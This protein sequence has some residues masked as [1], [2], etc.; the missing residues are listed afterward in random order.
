MKTL[1]II[2]EAA[3]IKLQELTPIMRKNCPTCKGKGMI[4]TD[5]VRKFYTDCKDCMGKIPKLLTY[6]E[7][8]I[9]DEFINITLQ[10]TRNT[11]TTD[12]YKKL[13]EIIEKIDKLIMKYSMIMYRYNDAFSYG[14]GTAAAM[15]IKR[16]IDKGY[17]CF[18][19]NNS[20]FLDL[21]FNF[22]QGDEVNFKRTKIY[23]FITGVQVLWID[24]FGDTQTGNMP[25]GSYAYKKVCTFLN[26]RKIQNRF[27]ILSTDATKDSFRGTYIGALTGLIDQNYLPFEIQCNTGKGK[28][29]AIAKL[30]KEDPDLAAI[31]NLPPQK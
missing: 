2:H 23:E 15:I 3:M 12:I 4:V 8:N 5:P 9:R 6:Y 19:I 10:D 7:A 21:M 1:D 14:T 17:T 26:N 22:G 30:G 18:S 27:T 31:F 11:Y 25:V 24:N 28:H 20:D 13:V 29:S 16:L